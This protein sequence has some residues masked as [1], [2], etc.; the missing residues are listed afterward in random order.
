M[1]AVYEKRLYSVEVLPIFFFIDD[2]GS[3]FPTPYTC[4]TFINVVVLV[5]IYVCFITF[6][7]YFVAAEVSNQDLYQHA[8]KLFTVLCRLG[9][10]S[11]DALA[12]VTGIKNSIA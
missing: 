1:G 11:L 7:T 12:K 4:I 10:L 5:N 9:G 6:I 3:H 8:Y 2:A